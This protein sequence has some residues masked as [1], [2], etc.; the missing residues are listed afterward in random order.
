MR[1]LEFW[2]AGSV[3]SVFVTEKLTVASAPGASVPYGLES[4]WRSRRR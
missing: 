4:R 1:M 2:L 3:A